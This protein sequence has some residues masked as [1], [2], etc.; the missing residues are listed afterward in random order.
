VS[1]DGGALKAKRQQAIRSL[2]AREHL[3]S[4]QE[5]RARLMGL[6]LDAT[7]STISRDVEELGLA[8]MH[9]HTGVHYVVPGGS[10]PPA[11][12]NLLRRSLRE[13]ALSFARGAGELL[14][15]HTP[16]GAAAAL[17]EALDRATL[18]GVAGTIA[19]DDT[20]LVIPRDGSTA[21]SVERSLA[22]IMDASA[23]GEATGEG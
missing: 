13:F 11:S 21:I 9:D 12:E 23:G 8:R 1:R 19:G 7:Q 20:I 2:V 16:P 4:Q 10:A 22:E 17:G 15:I 6:G 3:S 18:A 14:V 5:I